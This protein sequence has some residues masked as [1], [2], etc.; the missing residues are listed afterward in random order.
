MK[1]WKEAT[2]NVPGAGDVRVAV[3]SGLGNTRRLIE[4]MKRGE[5][6]YDFIEVM[7]CPGG[8]AGGGG[9]PITEGYEL[10][11]ERNDVLWRLDRESKLRFSHENPDVQA[12]YAQYLEKPLGH[13]SHHL[14]HTDHCAWTMPQ[15]V[16]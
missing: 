10:A 13:K 5:V 3:T 8:C 2:F 1:G 12:L 11:E 4:A 6:E 16:K 14:L 15:K 7:A 9:Q